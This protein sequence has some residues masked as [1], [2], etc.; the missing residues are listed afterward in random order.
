[1]NKNCGLLFASVVMLF[2]RRGSTPTKDIAVD[3]QADPKASFS[4]YKTCTWM[5][6][7]TAEIQQSPDAKT[8][9]ARLDH[10]VTQLFRKLFK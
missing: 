4:G 5:G 10:V 6:M 9:R 8:V 7:A 1:V 2:S 3:A